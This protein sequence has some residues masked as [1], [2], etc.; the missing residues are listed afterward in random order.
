MQASEKGIT[1]EDATEMGKIS[2]I[3]NVDLTSSVQVQARL[4]D[5][6]SPLNGRMLRSTAATPCIVPDRHPQQ[7]HPADPSNICK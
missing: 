4:E 7:R 3:E 1:S 2:S 5:E 6:L